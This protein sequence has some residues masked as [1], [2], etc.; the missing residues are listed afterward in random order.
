M[1]RFYIAGKIESMESVKIL[2][3]ALVG[4]GWEI[5]YDWTTHGSVRSGPN[6]DPA[7]L[8]PVCESELNGVLAADVVVVLLPGGRG[9]HAELGA[10]LASWELRGKPSWLVVCAPPGSEAL[11]GGDEETTVFYHHPRVDQIVCGLDA[12]AAYL[13]AN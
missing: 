8:G 1:K 3:D 2:R 5:T 10:A 13:T 12:L 7:L 4:Y 6:A 9:T 11:L